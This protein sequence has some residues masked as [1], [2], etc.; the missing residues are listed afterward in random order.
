MT[1]LPFSCTQRKKSKSFGQAQ[2]PIFPLNVTDRRGIS[3]VK[4]VFISFKFS[5]NR[6]MR[7]KDFDWLV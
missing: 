7:N 2:F 6:K 1:K 4:I 3:D 5:E